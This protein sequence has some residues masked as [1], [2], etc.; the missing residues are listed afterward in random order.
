MFASMATLFTY[1]DL[2]VWK[3]GMALTELCYRATQ[4]FPDGERY[5]LIS[6]MRRAAA[7]IPSNIAEGHCRRTT[8][9]FANHVSI[10]LGS[11]GELSTCV[12]LSARLGFLRPA[13]LEPLLSSSNSV[14]RLLYGLYQALERKLASANATGPN[15]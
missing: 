9:A 6:Q 8:K 15:L 13:D 7:S 10:A 2:D 5:G 4:T 14:G 1:R 3:Q 12:E 11:H